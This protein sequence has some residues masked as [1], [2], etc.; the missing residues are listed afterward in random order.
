MLKLTS[1]LNL[2]Y[3]ETIVSWT[4]RVTGE[5][6]TVNFMTSIYG[7]DSFSTVDIYNYV[8]QYLAS[9]PEV[10]QRNIFESYKGIRYT[11]DN[12]NSHKD[13]LN[14]VKQYIADICTE[15]P[16]ENINMWI[17]LSSDMR[18][19]SGFDDKYFDDINSNKS[20]DKTYL[21][22]DYLYLMAFSLG[23]RMMIPI[24]GEHMNLIRRDIGTEFKEYNSFQLLSKSPYIDSEPYTKLLM[25]IKSTITQAEYNDYNILVN[26]ISTEDF[27]YYIFCLTCVRRVPFLD[28]KYLGE[29]TKN[30]DLNALTYIYKFIKQRVKGHSDPKKV[31]RSKD[32]EG[33]DTNE[34]NKISVLEKYK[35][36]TDIS[37]EDIVELEYSV[38]DLDNI[39]RILTVAP[40]AQTML[41]NALKTSSSL[42]HSKIPDA[43]IRLLQ[44]TFKPV[45]SPRG[46]MY[47]SKIT[48]VKLLAALETVLW[49][50]GHKQLALLATCKREVTDDYVQVVSID[51]RNRV[52]DEYLVELEK[53]YPFS[54]TLRV[55]KSSKVSSNYISDT[56][57]SYIT[58]A[59]S[60]ILKMTA[61][62]SLIKEVFGNNNSRRYIIQQDM[63]ISLAKFFIEIGRRSWV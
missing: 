51:N 22:S 16:L 6:E 38:Q 2:S 36:K 42:L 60:D 53:L 7:R 48:L 59:S 40:E 52:P 12:E 46:I 17:K 44:W 32:N 39:V 35:I 5:V 14:N 50:R 45:I 41:D 9:L 20:T 4:D 25:Y 21:K 49:C 61:D 56:I 8:N 27:A 15:I 29:D 47:L 43:S 54:R 1:T 23:I 18:V 55:S 58:T 13:L 34:D 10:K 62:E 3:P 19:P 31:V 24:W 28:I 26:S 33:G 11:L 63:K 37:L 30:D 57:D